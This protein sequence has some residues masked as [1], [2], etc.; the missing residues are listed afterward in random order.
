[1]LIMM[2][3]AAQETP[4]RWGI[5]GPGRIAENVAADFVH[6]RGGRLVA[7]GSRN[8][9]RAEAFAQRFSAGGSSAVTDGPI[10]AHGSYEAL[11]ADPE[12]DAVYIATPHAQHAAN[13]IATVRA[14]R[15]A[16]VEKAF[17]A[18][19]PGAVAVVEA[20]RAAGVFVMEAMWTRF[21]PAVVRARE[22]IA[23]GA[24][25]EVRAVTADLG[26]RRDFDPDD[27]L[28][29]LALGGGTL[30]DLGVYVVSFAQMVLGEPVDVVARGSLLSTGVDAEAG[31]LVDFGDGRTANLLTSFRAPT[32]GDARIF[33]TDGWIDVPP[34]FHH[35]KELHLHRFGK[36]PIVESYD[37]PGV[38]YSYEFDEVNSCL[39]AGATESSIMPTSDT[40]AVQSVLQSAADQLGVALR[41]EPFE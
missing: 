21:Q 8:V 11:L 38:G 28:F 31:L 32:P 13:A 18:T 34:R 41:D 14:G 3:T 7:V 25:G 40:L 16:L 4:I 37:T 39:A 33:G 26:V 12:V 1:M 15:A 24:I 2:S 36:D 22:L 9:D 19:Y 17:T 20:A 6:V 5:L 30:L 10:R 29:S 23:D 27:R 35:P